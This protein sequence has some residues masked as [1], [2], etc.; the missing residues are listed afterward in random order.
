MTPP[1]DRKLNE[2][3]FCLSENDVNRLFVYASKHKMTTAQAIT[4]VIHSKVKV[5]PLQ[6]TSHT[7]TSPTTPTLT[8]IEQQQ[9]K[10]A[11]SKNKP[12]CEPGA[13]HARRETLKELA[14][15]VALSIPIEKLIKSAAY[16]KSKYKGVTLVNQSLQNPWF[17]I[18]HVPR[19]IAGYFG[20]CS[21]IPLGSYK[22]ELDAAQAYAAA[23]QELQYF[24]HKFAQGELQPPYSDI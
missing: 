7:N 10:L 9:L 6:V 20:G 14:N 17:A 13:G 18:A 8:P 21:T 24:A 1:A 12:L 22:T 2:F 4:Q 5:Y 23:D 19:I 15:A 3:S 16:S 11:S